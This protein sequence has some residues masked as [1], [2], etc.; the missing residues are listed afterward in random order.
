MGSSIRYIGL[1]AQSKLRRG[2]ICQARHQFEPSITFRR[3]RDF[4]DREHFEWYVVTTSHGLIAPH[5]VIGADA[6]SL[7]TL[8]ACER[9][10]WAAQ[11]AAQLAGCADRFAQAPTFVL[12]AS[13]QY[14][15]LL[16]RAAPPSIQFELPLAGLSLGQRLRWYDE[17]LQIRSRVLARHTPLA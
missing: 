10:R 15:E 7:H 14:A 3:A 11:V 13:Q 17:R 4:C 1:V 5:Q 9:A 8:P 12:Y 2:D 6:P 16:M